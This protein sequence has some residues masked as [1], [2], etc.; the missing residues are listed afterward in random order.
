MLYIYCSVV[1][2]TVDG[3]DE[4]DDK[5]G[6]VLPRQGTFSKDNEREGSEG[7]TVPQA[8]CQYY[9]SIGQA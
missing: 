2:D 1:S 8:R 6:S 9:R 7:D 4:G 5:D 3:V